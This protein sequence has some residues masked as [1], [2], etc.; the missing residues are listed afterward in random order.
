MSWLGS[1]KKNMRNLTEIA[2]LHHT[3]KNY[4]A[5][6]YTP[7]Y[8]EYFTPIR[9]TAETIVEIGV[10][11][12]ES[13]K[14]WKEYFSSAQIVGLDIN[15][16][17]QA[18]EEERISVVIGNQGDRQFMLSVACDTLG[19]LDA[20]IDDGSH[21]PT[22]YKN[23]FDVLFPFVKSGGLYVIED[24]N[25]QL[26]KEAFDFVEYLLQGVHLGRKLCLG[27]REKVLNYLPALSDHLSP[28]QMCISGLHIHNNIFFIRRV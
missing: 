3:D 12:G 10:W 7:L 11:Q 14:M 21:V 15:P 27:D 26:S 6:F 4:S 8:D 17:C 19:Q 25:A 28:S 22:D 1:D 5:H 9:E 2:D 24:I 13:L 16:S 18:Y 23:S 20:V